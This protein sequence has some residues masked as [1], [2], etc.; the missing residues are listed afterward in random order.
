MNKRPRFKVSSKECKHTPRRSEDVQIKTRHSQDSQIEF[1]LLELEVLGC[2]ISLNK[3]L[4]DQKDW[5]K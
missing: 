5:F 3:V 2:P 1:H 4:K